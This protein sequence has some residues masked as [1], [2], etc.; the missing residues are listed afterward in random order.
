LNH[1]EHNEHNEYEEK[2]RRLVSSPDPTGESNALCKVS[3]LVVLVVPVVVNRFLDDGHFIPRGRDLPADETIC[4]R[5]PP[6]RNRLQR[7]R[8]DNGVVEQGP[9]HP[10]AAFDSHH[11]VLIKLTGVSP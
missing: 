10:R 2:P 1:N 8:A 6:W 4:N 11:T 9:G 5:L 3:L 7:A